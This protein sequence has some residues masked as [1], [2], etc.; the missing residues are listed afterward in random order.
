MEKEERIKKRHFLISNLE[1][2][3]EDSVYFRSNNKFMK[4]SSK[5]VVGHISEKECKCKIL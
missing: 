4:E 2:I 1:K 3:I 5:F